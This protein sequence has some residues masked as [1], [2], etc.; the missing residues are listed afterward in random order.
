MLESESTASAQA[1]SACR[2][3]DSPGSVSLAA[4]GTAAATPLGALGEAGGSWGAVHG[5][6]AG[7][8]RDEAE[9]R[10]SAPCHGSY[11]GRVGGLSYIFLGVGLS[12]LTARRNLIF[13]LIRW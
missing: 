8:R 1:S 2:A 3:G 6:A 7:G 5:A 9:Q 13:L 12:S 4:Q 11:P 10:G